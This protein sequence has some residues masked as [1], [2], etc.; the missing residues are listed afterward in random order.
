MKTSL[1]ALKMKAVSVSLAKLNKKHFK[2]VDP[3]APPSLKGD[4]TKK[5]PDAPAVSPEKAP[6]NDD[7]VDDEDDAGAGTP[8]ARVPVSTKKEQTDGDDD[9]DVADGATPPSPD[10]QPLPHIA[11]DDHSPPIGGEG[12]T[13]QQQAP[14][15]G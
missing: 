4:D 7:E 10:D 8:G 15:V 1:S 9:N 5:A 13:E 6:E 11:D 2:P 3:P 14:S 12:A